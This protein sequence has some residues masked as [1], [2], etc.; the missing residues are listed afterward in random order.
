MRKINFRGKSRIDGTWV[1]G[2]LIHITFHDK[3]G[4][5]IADGDYTK[6]C[7]DEDE[8]GMPDVGFVLGKDIFPVYEETIGQYTG[9]KDKNGCQIYEGDVL[10]ATA[11]DD[12]GSFRTTGVVEWIDG[13][14]GYVM[15]AK[16]GKKC[17][18]HIFSDE[19][20]VVG[21][22]QD[23][24]AKYEEELDNQRDRTE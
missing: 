11:W 9:M 5:F 4:Y 17:Y 23:I 8:E 24:D 6:S 21:C 13:R 1:Y 19:M 14:F 18:T 12:S 22:I 16:D 3:M 15:Y 10:H 20:E 2:D 7:L